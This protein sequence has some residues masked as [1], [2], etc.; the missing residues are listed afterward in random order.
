MP[1]RKGKQP[2]TRRR[3]VVSVPIEGTNI[4]K[5]V[6]YVKTKHGVKVDDSKPKRERGRPPQQDVGDLIEKSVS[7]IQ[8]IG[9]GRREMYMVALAYSDAAFV[10]GGD[11]ERQRIHRNCREIQASESGRAQLESTRIAYFQR[12]DRWGLRYE[13]LVDAARIEKPEDRLLYLLWAQGTKSKK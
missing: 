1:G 2:K 9:A 10:A 11:G 8:T 6:N 4:K 7:I 5:G 3:L 13:W 12:L